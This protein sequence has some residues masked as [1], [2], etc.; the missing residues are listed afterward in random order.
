M[1][2]KSLQNNVI[3]QVRYKMKHSSKTN[4][5]CL[6]L[7]IHVLYMLLLYLHV[8]KFLCVLDFLHGY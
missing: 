4:K 5:Q 6:Y 8:N 1:Y 2:V 7:L 3:S